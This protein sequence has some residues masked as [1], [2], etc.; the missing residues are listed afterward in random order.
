MDLRQPA[1]DLEPIELE[2]EESR[3]STSRGRTLTHQPLS[4]CRPSPPGSPVVGVGSGEDRLEPFALADQAT[5]FRRDSADRDELS[6]GRLGSGLRR[7][8]AREALLIDLAAWRGL[9]SG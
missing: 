5:R 9:V 1:V 7:R 3:A 8:G 6:A 4:G 2:P